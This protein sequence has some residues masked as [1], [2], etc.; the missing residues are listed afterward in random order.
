MRGL[1]EIA[2]CMLSGGEFYRGV[3]RDTNN[4]ALEGVVGLNGLS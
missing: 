3:R 2:Y 4:T 1:S